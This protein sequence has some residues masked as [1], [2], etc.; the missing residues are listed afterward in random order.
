MSYALSRPFRLSTET[1]SRLT[2][3]HPELIRRMA[4][5]GLLEVSRDAEGNLWFDPSQVAAMARIRRIRA[6]LNVNYAALG[7][8]L[9]LLDR[10]DQLEQS[11]QRQ[12]SRFRGST[13]T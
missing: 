10:I 13:W 4:A 7:L 9:D 5:L 8:V 3:V 6:G 12:P 1:Y 2:G 11:R